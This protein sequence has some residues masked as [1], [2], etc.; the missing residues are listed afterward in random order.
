MNQGKSESVN[1]LAC[2]I[3]QAITLNNLCV[4]ELKDGNNPNAAI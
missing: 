2:K 1:T 3:Q 4:I